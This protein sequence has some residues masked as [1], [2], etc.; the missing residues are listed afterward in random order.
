[1]DSATVSQLKEHILK[2][3]Q[4]KHPEVKLAHIRLHAL[5]SNVSMQQG[6]V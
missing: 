6:I 5:T 4:L 2:K 3:I 1:M